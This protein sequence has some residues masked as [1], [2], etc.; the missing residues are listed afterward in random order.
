[1]SESLFDAP[2]YLDD[3]IVAKLADT[4]DFKGGIEVQNPINEQAQKKRQ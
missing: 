3:K 2:F 1:M 4:G